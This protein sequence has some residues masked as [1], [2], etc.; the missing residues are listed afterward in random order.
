MI[1]TLITLMTLLSIGVSQHITE[2]TVTTSPVIVEE[3]ESCETPQ[4][5]D[6]IYDYPIDTLQEIQK[7]HFDIIRLDRL[8]DKELDKLKGIIEKGLT[9]DEF[10]LD[11]AKQILGWREV[12]NMYNYKSDKEIERKSWSWEGGHG[13]RLER[14]L[15]QGPSVWFLRLFQ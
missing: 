2:E 10:S 13:K 4:D 11:D 1:S 14:F 7:T 8:L 6:T 9:D 5:I 15:D 12:Q 3:T